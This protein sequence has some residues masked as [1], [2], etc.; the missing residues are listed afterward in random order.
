M[1]TDTKT[2]KRIPAVLA[3]KNKNSK[4]DRWL[5]YNEKKR[6]YFSPKAI[7]SSTKRRTMM[8]RPIEELHK[9]NNVEATIFN[10]C[11]KLRNGKSKYRGLEKNQTWAICRCLWV[12]LVRIMHFSEQPCQR[13]VQKTKSAAFLPYFWIISVLKGTYNRKLSRQLSVLPMLFFIIILIYF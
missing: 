6:I 8:Q 3:K 9:R 7:R 13:N 5:I 4:E 2:G 11:C 1:V 10:L 12:N